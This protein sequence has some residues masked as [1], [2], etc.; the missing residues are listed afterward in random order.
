[1]GNLSRE[2]VRSCIYG[3][4]DHKW[5][6][7]GCAFLP[8]YAGGES[9]NIV[10][11]GGRGS[12]IKL[13]GIGSFCMDARFGL[14][15]AGYECRWGA[16]ACHGASL[17]LP[18][19][20]SPI[21][22]TSPLPPVLLAAVY[23]VL[24]SPSLSAPLILACFCP[25]A[26]EPLPPPLPLLPSLPCSLPLPSPAFVPMPMTPYPCAPSLLPSPL[27]VSS[28]PPMPP[29]LP[30]PPPLHG[31]PS[32]GVPLLRA[33]SRRRCWPGGRPQAPP[34]RRRR[35]SIAGPPQARRLRRLAPTGQV[36]P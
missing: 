5:C 36:A 16:R 12:G 21:H 33:W 4:V 31:P 35:R 3:G 7:V 29:T 8:R 18:L 2:F 10:G 34:A 20:L 22:P 11:V 6:G 23:H 26:N 1:M 14:G 28:R 17:P 13:S 9:G 15:M 27:S 25:H 19:S 30:T 24:F 32:S